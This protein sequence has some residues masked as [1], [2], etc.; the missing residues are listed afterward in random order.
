[1]ARKSK[2]E[3]RSIIK[4]ELKSEVG[5]YNKN[6]N[7]NINKGKFAFTK[8]EMDKCGIELTER[9]HE[10]YKMIRNNTI[11]TVQGA[12]GCAKTFVA[13]YTALRMLAEKK[14][15]KIV[16]TKL[17][18][19][20]GNEVIGILPGNITDKTD[21]YMNSY[22]SNIEKIIGKQNLAFL[23]A[24]D[25]IAVAPIA[26]MRGNTYDDSLM[27]LDEAQ[28][29]TMNQLILWATRIGKN[30]RCLIIGDG[31]QLDIK[32]R[33]SKFSDFIKMIDGVDGV[34]NFKFN[35]ED[36][37]RSKI[38]IDIVDRYEKYKDEHD[39]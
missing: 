1:M 24:N 7:T 32:K 26:L 38:L 12:A 37:V 10:L 13:C 16:L 18:Q 3:S 20:A 27:I 11:T 8:A 33:D 22:F 9:Q 21:V 28:N 35:K 19:D 23:R 39:M 14:I 30:S 6:N 4:E 34:S 2:S 36:I 5:D 25:M 15:S 31:S 17:I 29:C